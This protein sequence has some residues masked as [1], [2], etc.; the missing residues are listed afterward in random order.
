MPDR[1]LNAPAHD[2]DVDRALP[3]IEHGREHVELI[4]PPSSVLHVSLNGAERRVGM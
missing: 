3:R 4:E 2:V 1:F